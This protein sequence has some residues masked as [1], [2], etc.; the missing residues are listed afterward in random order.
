MDVVVEKALPVAYIE[1]IEDEDGN[2]RREGPRGEK[3]E[4]EQKDK[5]VV[6]ACNLFNVTNK[7]GLNVKIPGPL[8]EGEIQT[9]G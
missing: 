1:F 5:W 3:E 6:S 2:I 9:L 4:M 8:G 7:Q